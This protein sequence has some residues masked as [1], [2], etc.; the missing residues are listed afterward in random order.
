MTA[1]HLIGRAVAAHREKKEKL[2]M[3]EHLPPNCRKEIRTERDKQDWNKFIETK[4]IVC[5]PLPY[6]QPQQT[7]QQQM[8]STQTGSSQQQE[9]L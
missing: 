9:T 5:D 1:G 4:Y 7:Q 3:S 8:V 6:Q 2:D